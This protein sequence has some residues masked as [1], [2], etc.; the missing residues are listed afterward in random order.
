MSLVS[1]SSKTQWENSHWVTKDFEQF[2]MG[3]DGFSVLICTPHNKIKSV[4]RGRQLPAIISY[5]S[6]VVANFD[7]LRKNI[8]HF[9]SFDKIKMKKLKIKTSKHCKLTIQFEIN[10]D[11]AQNG[12]K[13][14]NTFKWET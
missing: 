4:S 11:N 3:Y 10:K 12:A 8:F 14:G 13:T 2:S 9:T 1:K 7:W 6:N 5:F